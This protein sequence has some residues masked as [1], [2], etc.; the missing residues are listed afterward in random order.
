MLK[1]IGLIGLGTVGESVLRALKKQSDLICQR[2]SV[3]IE[4]KKI[5]DV[6][7]AK[8]KLAKD[9]SLAFTTN[10]KDLINDP[11]IDII[12]ELI[13]GVEPAKSIIIE[14]LCLK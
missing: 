12:V 6:N 11:E 8:N 3:K 9:L 7:K 10:P 14:R 2:T 4:V 5:C 13:G 1:K